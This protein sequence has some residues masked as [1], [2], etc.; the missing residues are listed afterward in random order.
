MGLAEPIRDDVSEFQR[1]LEAV[2]GPLGGEAAARLAATKADLRRTFDSLPK[3]AAGRLAPQ[4]VRHIVHGYMARKHGWHLQGLEPHGMKKS[5]SKALHEVSVVK[6]KAP[7]LKRALLKIRVAERGVA[8]GEVAAYVATLE[9]LIIHEYIPLIDAAY[10]FN[11]VSTGEPV[12]QAALETILQ[13]FLV[14]LNIGEVV[15]SHSEHKEAVA[16]AQV[17]NT[18][19]GELVDFVGDILRNSNFAERHRRS[20]FAQHLYPFPESWEVMEDVVHKY[21]EW[22]NKDCKLMKQELMGLTRNSSGR[23]PLSRFYGHRDRARFK[24][25]ESVD[26]L[27]QIGSL[28]NSEQDNPKVILANYLIG[29]SNCIANF[30]Q[31]SVC[32]LNECL[33]LMGKVEE[34]IGSP[35]ASLEQLLAAVGRLTSATVEGPRSFEPA[36][37]EKLRS[38]ASLHEGK[39]PLHGRLFAQWLHFAFPN[40]CPYPSIVEGAAAFIPARWHGGI[41]YTAKRERA[42]YVK[43]YGDQ[44]ETV[45]PMAQWT[46]DEVLPLRIDASAKGFEEEN[47]FDSVFV[48]LVEL[49]AVALVMATFV[50][51]SPA[52]WKRKLKW[53]FKWAGFGKEEKGGCFE[54]TKARPKSET[55]GKEARKGA[56]GQASGAE[57][58]KQQK[59]ESEVP[60]QRKHV[61]NAGKEAPAKQLSPPTPQRAARETAAVMTKPA[62]Q[63]PPVELAAVMIKPPVQPPS[64]E[65]V[66]LT[67]DTAEKNSSPAGPELDVSGIESPS[68]LEPWEPGLEVPDAGIEP[69]SLG[70]DTPATAGAST[71]SRSTASSAADSESASLAESAL[72]SPKE[73]EA[74]APVSPLGRLDAPP[75]LPDLSS[76]APPGLS[77]PWGGLPGLTVLAAGFAGAHGLDTGT[78]TSPLSQISGDG[79]LPW[80]RL[81]DL[82]PKLDPKVG[83]SINRAPPG[84]ELMQAAIARP[85]PGSSESVRREASHEWLEQLQQKQDGE[86]KAVVQARIARVQHEKSAKEQLL[87]HL[88]KQ[89]ARVQEDIAGISSKLDRE[90]LR[91]AVAPR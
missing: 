59:R 8:L 2:L 20:P 80:G 36:M 48:S 60:R 29:P 5:S 42:M 13:S 86:T 54:K 28:D 61:Q 91:L 47:F 4:A 31:H 75:G 67:P 1:S 68:R 73:E 27:L 24:F 74:L 63:P 51:V 30:R 82:D 65:L 77:S 37:V 76:S 34:E 40:E 70:V 66:E 25:S 84:L 10:K 62:E 78:D 71:S 45:V 85:A 52:V 57:G 53:L 6:E 55:N 22:Q 39:I 32:C 17:K 9:Q 16:S 35:E 56:R 90:A 11:N 44:N 12:D 18:T 69:N 89:A 88:L 7:A 3:N 79:S 43:E 50:G 19:W 21:A 41:G 46:D 58:K 26:Y 14:M 87:A 33:T 83:S 81:P 72:R 38:V 15:K 23:V 49:M 64:V